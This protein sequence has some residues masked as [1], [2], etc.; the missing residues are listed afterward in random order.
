ME[1]LSTLMI[2]NNVM[3][4]QVQEAKEQLVAGLATAQAG[5]ITATEDGGASV[6]LHRL[7]LNLSG[8]W[9]FRMAF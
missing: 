2:G 9:L 1:A 8:L 4:V 6:R 3:R 5:Y 7:D